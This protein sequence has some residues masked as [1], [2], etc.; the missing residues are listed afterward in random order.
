MKDLDKMQV[1]AKGEIGFLNVIVKPLWV[2][3]NKIYDNK[4]ENE[5]KNIE[6][7]INSWEKI[8]EEENNIKKAKINEAF[9]SFDEIHQLSSE[10]FK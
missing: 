8:Q 10:E 7:N 9:K 6:N 3:V 5:V 4:F 1:M 2:L